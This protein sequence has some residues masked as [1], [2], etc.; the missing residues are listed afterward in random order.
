MK[1][2]LSMATERWKIAIYV[3]N[4]KGGGAELVSVRLANEFAAIGHDVTIIANSSEGAL[5]G[6]V[7]ADVKVVDLGVSRTLAAMPKLIA[8]L[9]GERPAIFISGF[10]YNNIAALL[11]SWP[12]AGR[13]I[14]SSAS[15]A[16]GRF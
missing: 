16:S 11:P 15:T 8:Y 10:I 7:A 9:K 5:R 3:P 12:A 14:S 13:D 4:F 6:D 2:S 1:G